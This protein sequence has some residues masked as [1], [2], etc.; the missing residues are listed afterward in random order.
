VGFE[1]LRVYA[2]SLIIFSIGS[3]PTASLSTGETET[4]T[5]FSLQKFLDQNT[6]VHAGGSGSGE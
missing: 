4:T 6:W 5:K 3:L 2:A 1:I